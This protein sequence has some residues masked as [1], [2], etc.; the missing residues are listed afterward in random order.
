MRL[1]VRLTMVYVTLHLV[2]VACA[3]S[4]KDS[5]LCH[6]SD[7]FNKCRRDSMFRLGVSAECNQTTDACQCYN[8]NFPFSISKFVEGAQ[9]DNVK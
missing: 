6:Y 8:F 7:C 9:N 2:I 4:T 3:R 5:G 1:L